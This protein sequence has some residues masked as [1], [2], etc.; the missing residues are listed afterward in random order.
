MQP[1]NPAATR[2][3]NRKRRN[4]FLDLEIRV[5]LEFV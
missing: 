2:L 4:V 5:R 1:G 3:R